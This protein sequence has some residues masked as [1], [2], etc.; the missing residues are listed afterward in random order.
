[1]DVLRDSVMS[2]LIFSRIYYRTA[3]NKVV[4]S[5]IILITHST[6]KIKSIF[7]YSGLVVLGVEA[8]VLCS[9]D[10]SF[11]FS[12]QTHTMKPLMVV[13]L[14]NISLLASLWVSAVQRFFFPG[15]FYLFESFSL[16]FLKN[17]LHVV[18]KWLFRLSGLVG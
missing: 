4:Y 1:M 16:S 13:W 15:F 3:K 2:I 11:C 17:F 10:K 14:I 7:Y 18:Y 9:H 8:L 12:F 5:F 6:F